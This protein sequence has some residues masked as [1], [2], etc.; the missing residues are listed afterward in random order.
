MDTE[1]IPCPLCSSSR[2]REVCRA[3]D[4]VYEIA[5]EWRFSQCLDCG[6]VYLNPRPVISQLM[7]CYPDSYGPHTGMP[8]EAASSSPHTSAESSRL[9]EGRRWGRMIPGAR[10]FLRWLGE[11]NS[12]VLPPPP[13]SGQSRLLE[14]GCAHGA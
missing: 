9:S 4:Y 12:T 1:L 2:E 5:G 7:E 13:V 14:I 11:E 10:R 6:H 8:S 3:R